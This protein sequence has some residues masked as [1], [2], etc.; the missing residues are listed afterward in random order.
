MLEALLEAFG[1]QDGEQPPLLRDPGW[2]RIASAGQPRA[3]PPWKAKP[4]VREPLCAEWG[5]RPR[6]VV[7]R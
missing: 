2:E 4:F 1:Q 7:L 5:A 3:L 6:P